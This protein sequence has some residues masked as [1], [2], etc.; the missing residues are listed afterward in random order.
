MNIIAFPHYDDTAARIFTIL[1]V[2]DRVRWE[3]TP[4]EQIRAS[5]RMAW[6]ESPT[7]PPGVNTFAKAIKKAKKD[8]L[9]LTERG[10]GGGCRIT[11]RGRELFVLELTARKYLNARILR[12]EY[13]A[14]LWPQPP[15]AP[16]LPMAA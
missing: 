16:A 2:L 15:A 8:G 7:S 9:L 4:R 11:E 3:F 14:L 6:H 10:R 1:R 5:L 12:K 13:R